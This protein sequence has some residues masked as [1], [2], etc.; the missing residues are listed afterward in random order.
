MKWKN[1]LWMIR[2]VIRK[3]WVWILTIIVAM[4]C[5]F[6]PYQKNLLDFFENP[7]TAEYLFWNNVYLFHNVFVLIFMFHIAVQVLNMETFELYLMWKWQIRIVLGIVFFMYQIL[8][9][10]EYIWYVSV[11]SDAISKV[12]LLIFIEIGNIFLFYAIS[13]KSRK[14]VI[15][16]ATDFLLILLLFGTGKI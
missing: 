8:V 14:I 12:F 11:Y 9:L 6:V 15:G 10:P 16:F 7:E 2:F 5:V 1:V 3:K 4:Y 13:V